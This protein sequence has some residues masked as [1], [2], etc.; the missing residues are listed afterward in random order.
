MRIFKR[1]AD[2]RVVHLH[3]DIQRWERLIIKQYT[4]PDVK[5]G[6]H[7]LEQSRVRTGQSEDVVPQ[8]VVQDGQIS[9][10]QRN[11]RAGIFGQRRDCVRQDQFRSFVHITDSDQN[12][13]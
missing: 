10:F 3:G 9:D 7:D 8:R 1:N 2:R 12:N 5:P 4:L 6:I 13:G 11:D